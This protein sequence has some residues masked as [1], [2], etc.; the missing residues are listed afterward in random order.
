MKQLSLWLLIVL[1]SACNSNEIPP[2]RIAAS[3]NTQFAIN[4]IAEAFENESHIKT[5]VILGSSGKLTAQIKNGAPYDVFLSADS[6]FPNYLYRQNV[7]PFSPTLYAKGRIV[8]WTVDNTIDLDQL[9]NLYQKKLVIAN[10]KTAPYGIAAKSYYESFLFKSFTPQNMVYA[11]SIT[12]VNQ[13]VSTGAVD[14][15][16]TSLSSVLS[17]ALKGQGKWKMIDTIYHKPI[18]QSLLP[19]ESKIH[20]EKDVKKFIDFLSTPIAKQIFVEY[21]YELIE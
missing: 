8:L 10:P 13:Y 7:T 11:E 3:A 4:A 2:I 6:A 21:G 5:E 16:I 14:L 9:N 20:S 17:P 15:G 1:L 19:L 18:L 12:Q